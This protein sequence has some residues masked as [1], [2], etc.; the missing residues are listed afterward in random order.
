MFDES[1]PDDSPDIVEGPDGPV[2][3]RRVRGSAFIEPVETR[4]PCEYANGGKARMDE[5][6]AYYNSRFLERNRRT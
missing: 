5:E 6:D 2:R 4:L 3:H 1:T